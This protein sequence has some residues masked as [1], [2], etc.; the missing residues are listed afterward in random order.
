MRPLA[1]AS[2]VFAFG[3]TLA[4]ATPAL[5]MDPLCQSLMTMQA[6]N[7]KT[8]FHMYM[9]SQ[10]TFKNAASARAGAQIGMAGTKKSEEISTG[11]DIYV[12]HDGKWIDMKTDPSK[13]ADPDDEDAKASREAARCH[14]LPDEMVAGQPASV[15]QQDNAADGMHLKFW[16]S[17]STHLMLKSE[18]TTD[19]GPMKQVALSTYDYKNVQAP[20]GAMTMQQMMQARHH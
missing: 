11:K 1:P 18:L 6:H 9:T 20:S 8:P 10:T 19:A 2:L 13:K 15:Y 17:K 5:A 3:T 7:A 14:A 12:L 16:M 4:C